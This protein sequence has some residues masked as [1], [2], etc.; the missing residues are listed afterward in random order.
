[1]ARRRPC[2]ICKHW[3]RPDPRTGDRQRVCGRAECQRERHRQACARWR[4]RNP[5]YDREGRWRARLRPTAPAASSV[6]ADP[7]DAIDWSAARDAIG[8]EASVLV[9]ETGQVLVRWARDAISRQ[10][11]GIPSDS[12]KYPPPTPRDDMVH[13]PRAP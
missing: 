10:G 11:P 2:R 4:E 8:L 13:R 12:R 3:F 5:D 1:M 6:T 9:E 7:L